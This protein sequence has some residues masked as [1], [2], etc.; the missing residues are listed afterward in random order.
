VNQ[1]AVDSPFG[2]STATTHYA[3]LNDYY[4]HH[5]THQTL[6]RHDHSLEIFLQH[7][8]QNVFRIAP[9]YNDLQHRETMP[10]DMVDWM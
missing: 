6:I 2:K 9:E 8:G 1:K 4:L 3:M 5:N 10:D 7:T